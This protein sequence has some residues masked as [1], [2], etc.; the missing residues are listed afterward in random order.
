MASVVSGIAT[1]PPDDEAAVRD[2][3]AGRLL[4]LDARIACNAGAYSVFPWTAGLEALMAGGKLEGECD[5][6]GAY[7]NAPYSADYVFL[8]KG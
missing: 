8:R 2:K 3:V 4:A 6:T 1:E 7:R 5:K